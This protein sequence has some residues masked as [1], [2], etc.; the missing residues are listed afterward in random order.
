MCANFET[1]S[2]GPIRTMASK[3]VLIVPQGGKMCKIKSNFK[4]LLG[5]LM[6]CTIKVVQIERTR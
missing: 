6:T 3:I 4:N 5:N 2:Y 1:K